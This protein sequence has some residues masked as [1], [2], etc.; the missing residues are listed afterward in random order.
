MFAAFPDMHFTVRQQIAEGDKVLTHK[1]FHGTHRG[2]FM[3]IPATG[4][5]VSIDVMDIFTV[6]DGRM[7]EHWTVSDMLGMLQQLGVAPGP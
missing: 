4:K 7:R 1:T 2:P 6:T 5:E 3:G